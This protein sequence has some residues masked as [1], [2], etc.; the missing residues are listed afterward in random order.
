MMVIVAF[1]NAT[2]PN[3]KL[4]KTQPS[5]RVQLRRFLNRLPG[6]L[7]K[8]VL[9]LMKNVLRPLAKSVLIPLELTANS[10]TDT[11]I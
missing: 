10:A 7:L 9:F 5:K 4:W 2:S 3:T 11:A 6:P 1:A 8:T